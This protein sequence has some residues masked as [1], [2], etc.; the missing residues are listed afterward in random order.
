MTYG[1]TGNAPIVSRKHDHLVLI[2][3]I[4]IKKHNI[5]A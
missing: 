5:G 4:F 1:L 2:M 3:K